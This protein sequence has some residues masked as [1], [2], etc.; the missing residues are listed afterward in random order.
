MR[1]RWTLR[2]G[3]IAAVVYAGYETHRNRLGPTQPDRTAALDRALQHPPGMPL[4][5]ITF[6]LAHRRGPRLIHG[7]RLPSAAGM[8]LWSALTTPLFMLA[9]KIA[10]QVA[11]RVYRNVLRR[12]YIHV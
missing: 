12:E 2:T 6:R 9:A 4:I 8:T 7:L 1:A 10:L 5:N 11:R 3:G